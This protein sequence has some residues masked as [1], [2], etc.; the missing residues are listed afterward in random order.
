MVALSASLNT[1]DCVADSVLRRD[2]GYTGVSKTV[3]N[4]RHDRGV[5]NATAKPVGRTMALCAMAGG[6]VRRVALT[7]NELIE[8]LNKCPATPRSVG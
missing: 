3:L 2:T 4:F 8:V 5:R 6:T 7:K 1:V